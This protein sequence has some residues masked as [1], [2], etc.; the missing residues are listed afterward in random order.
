MIRSILVLIFCV[1]VFAVSQASSSNSP[2]TVTW[3][4]KACKIL[5]AQSFAKELYSDRWDTIEISKL[6]YEPR[7]MCTVK[8]VNSKTKQYKY[9]SIKNCRINN[10][11]GS[12][13][14]NF[15]RISPINPDYQSTG[16]YRKSGRTFRID[17]VKNGDVVFVDDEYRIYVYPN[18][19]SN[20]GDEFMKQVCI[21]L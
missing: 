19:I 5:E 4:I 3:R 8:F 13:Y 12:V 10:A 2:I 7:D 1:S 15:S 14:S 11:T 9:D 16:F 18:K 20:S 6:G 21:L 17:Q